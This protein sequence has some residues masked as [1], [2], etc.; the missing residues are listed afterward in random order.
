MATE[1]FYTVVFNDG[2]EQLFLKEF[3]VASLVMLQNSL[4]IRKVVGQEGAE[5]MLKE[6]KRACEFAHVKK[7]VVMSRV[8]VYTP[9]YSERNNEDAAKF[10]DIANYKI[11]PLSISY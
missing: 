11:I 6:V 9:A 2:T 10:F 1:Q 7:H 4:S 5:K 8:I 3:N